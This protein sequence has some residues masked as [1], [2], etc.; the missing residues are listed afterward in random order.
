VDQHHKHSVNHK[1]SLEQID[2]LTREEATQK[3]SLESGFSA[4]KTQ[5]MPGEIGKR[6]LKKSVMK[7]KSILPHFPFKTK[8]WMNL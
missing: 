6:V 2:R 1:E 7:V 3:Q 8:P 5:M 4:S